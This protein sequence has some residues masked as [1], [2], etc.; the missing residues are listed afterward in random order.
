MNNSNKVIHNKENISR[1]IHEIA[2]DI[3]KDYK[4]KSLD[5]ICLVNSAMVFTSDL[6][7]KIEIP[8]KLH[9]FDFSSINES[10][11][12]EVRINLD[13]KN[14]I[15]GKNVLIIEGL[16]ISGKTPKYIYNYFK[17]KYKP[18][19]LHFCVVGFKPHLLK[20][21]LSIKY[22]GFK[23]KSENVYGYGIGPSKYK[24]LDHLIDLKGL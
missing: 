8:I 13:I 17:K 16:I 24:K 18:L 19:S 6:I 2:K 21:D 22:Y 11:S 5:I 1:R 3:N 9:I 12:G 20:D 7:R 14:S 23:F 4:N 15:S 10:K